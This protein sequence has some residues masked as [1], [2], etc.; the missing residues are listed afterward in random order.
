[1]KSEFEPTFDFYEVFYKHGLRAG[2]MISG[3]KRAPEGHVAV[4]NGNIVIEK[5][6]KIWYGDLNLTLERE[7]LQA[8]ANELCRDLYILRE[9]DARFDN[10]DAG[11]KFWKSKA[12]D[13]I[14]C[15]TCKCK[16]K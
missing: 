4:F 10:E 15:E 3:S 11:M 9:H 1:M 5:H 16:K 8:I 2:R 6:G 14:L 12:V 7:K 13:V